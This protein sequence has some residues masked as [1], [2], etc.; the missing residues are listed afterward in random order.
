MNPIY[1]FTL[2][3]NDGEAGQVYPAYGDDLTK[4]YS[5]E[6]NQMFFR[7]KLSGK[8][9]FVGADYTTINAAAFDA[10]FSLTIYKSDNG[11]S[12]WETYWNGKFYKTDCEFDEDDR[13]IVV[14]PNVDDA[15]EAVLAGLSKEFNLIDLAPECKNVTYDRRPMVQIYVPGEESIGCFLSSMWWEQECESV[16]ETDEVTISGHNYNKLEYLSFQK[17][18]KKRIITITNQIQGA[19]L[20]ID[21][22]I[23]DVPDPVT[24]TYTATN[25]NY[26]FRTREE[27]HQQGYGYWYFYEILLNGQLYMQGRDLIMGGEQNPVP[28]LT[29]TLSQ[30]NSGA[31][32]PTIQI[33]V[34]D[35]SVYARMITDTKTYGTTTADEISDNDLVENNRN[36]RYVVKYDCSGS[37]VFHTALSTTPTKWGIYQPG[38]YFTEPPQNPYA[39]AME[40]MPVA[41]NAWGRV[42]IWYYMQPFEYTAEQ[43]WRHE[44]M[45]KDAYTLSSSI[46]VLL[47]QIAPGISHGNTTE[48][49]QFLYGTN[50]ITNVSQTLLIAP[51]SNVIKAG[52]DQPAQKAPITLGQIFEMLRDCFRCYWF[53]DGNKLK[54]EHIKY[55]RNGG[56]YNVTPTIGTDLT[57]TYYP[58][59]MKPWAYVTSKYKFSKPEM[60]ARYEFGWMDDVTEYFEGFPIDI[61]SGYVNPDN[62][63]KIDIGNFTA[64]IDYILLNP[65]AISM[66]GF[67]LMSATTPSTNLVSA[68]TANSTLKTDGTT[69]SASGYTVSDAILADGKD[70]ISNA[71]CPEG[72]DY[73]TYVVYDVNNNMIRW[74]REQNYYYEQGDYSVRFTFNTTPNAH[75]GNLVL[76]YLN[77]V[78]N[79]TDHILQN[80]YVAFVFLTDYYVWDMPAKYFKID[81][82]QY[83]AL[84]IKRLKSQEVNFP[85]LEDPELIKLIKTYMGNGEIQKI[86]INLSSRNAKATLMYDTQDL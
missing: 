44:C 53:I 7:A 73:V 13:T 42:S 11:G 84:G 8:L 18:A 31:Y 54:I 12:T 65:S 38:Q 47:G 86:S 74:S 17:V 75:Y 60:A 85:S 5:L 56:S 6:S 77:K 83:T 52:Y 35:I 82:T 29:E 28:P 57:T 63:E 68:T 48:Y 55:F 67:V 66:D 50:Q 70:V 36:Y 25:G 20:P 81:G 24:A 45:L 16:L 27:E 37:I 19:N 23:C 72:D 21:H 15:Y 32:P 2:A 1:K 58:R 69:T 22:F 51:K 49:S 78:R 80:A 30:I 10:K 26:T 40:F 59:S 33:E 64:D 61:V 14:T 3:I 62:I 76:P 9:T 39:G 46:S 4:E 71:A 79:S 34:R 43:S 41:R